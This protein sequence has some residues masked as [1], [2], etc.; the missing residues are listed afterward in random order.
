M[1]DPEELFRG[2][3]SNFIDIIRTGSELGVS[4]CVVTVKDLKLK[5]KKMI[6]YVYD[7]AAKKFSPQVIGLPHVLYNRIPLRQDESSHDVQQTIAA[8]MKHPQIRLF[9]PYFFDKW[10]LFEWL[11]KAKTTSK[12]IPST[13]KMTSS[14]ELE[15]LF[16]L[17]SAV[18]MKPVSGKA[19]KGIMKA[20]RH[21]G[22]LDRRP[23]Y[24]LSVQETKGSV[25]YK[26][27]KLSQLWSRIKEEIGHEDYIAQQGIS[28]VRYKKRPFDLRVLVQKNYKGEWDVTGIGARLAGKLSITTHVPRGG[29]IDDPE[30]LLASAFGA[31]GCKRILMRARK[32]ALAIARQV[33]K[34]SGHMLGEMSMDLGV[35]VHGGIWFFEAN[36][37]PMK[38]DEP[39]I[40][41]KS[42]ERIVHY[43]LYLIRSKQAKPGGANVVQTN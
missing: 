39:H 35:D 18:Y 6:G 31:E 10:S 43:A 15:S 42:L 34:K 28:L 38:F 17:H 2:N 27:A 14:Q 36:S 37:K 8:C 41:K 19:G 30:R 40:R 32:A 20:E 29:S 12:Y 3:R 16:K 4:V 21:I 11:N 5:Q 25:V 24:C 26:Y 1:D 23:E 33:E 7:P 22:K 13:R 9:N